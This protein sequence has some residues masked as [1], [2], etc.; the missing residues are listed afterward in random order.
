[1]PSKH[2]LP[3]SRW[4]SV[5]SPKGLPAAVT[6]TLAIG[7]SRMAKRRTVIRR[8]PAVET[9]GSTTVICADKTGT[10][11]ENQMTVQVIWTPDGLVEV[12]GTGYAPDG[13]LRHRD[14]APASVD[15]DVALR[16]SLL[17]GACCNDA[18]LAHDG[19]RGT[20]LVT[21]PRARCWWPPPRPGLDR[22]RPAAKLPRVE[23]IPFS[24]E[25]QFMATLHRDGASDQSCW[26]R[27][28]GADA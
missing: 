17:A 22:D 1:M 27:V 26:S 15:A 11:T 3:R 4:R 7:V 5:Q 12:T 19:G 18:A 16:W 28:G 2:S 14:G 10:L 6:I 24:S 8:L 20:S 21:L 13:V 25:R 23:A 9:L